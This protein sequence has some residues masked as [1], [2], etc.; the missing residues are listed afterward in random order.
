MENLSRSK[1]SSGPDLKPGYSLITRILIIVDHD[2]WMN[3]PL[4][5]EYLEYARRD[6]Y[7]IYSLYDYFSRVGYLSL[8]TA[9]QSMRYISLHRYC[10]PYRDNIYTSHP[11]LPLGILGE[12][13]IDGLTK[14]CL[15]CKRTLSLFGFSPFEVSSRCFVCRAVD[16][17]QTARRTTETNLPKVAQIAQIAQIAQMSDRQVCGSIPLSQGAMLARAHACATVP[18]LTIPRGYFASELPT[19]LSSARSP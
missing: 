19:H 11:F 16:I 18:T 15:R 12:D 17:R 14:T 7:L 10:P 1:V 4:P 2:L 13:A 9:E 8:V 5:D 6:A 3:R